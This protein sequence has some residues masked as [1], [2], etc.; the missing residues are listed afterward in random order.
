MYKDI[1][2]EEKNKAKL[3]ACIKEG[4]NIIVVLNQQRKN[5]EEI[6]GRGV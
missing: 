1:I 4:Y 3:T 5:Y 6:M 2:L